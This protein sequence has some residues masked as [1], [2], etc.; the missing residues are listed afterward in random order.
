MGKGRKRENREGA[1]KG[2]LRRWQDVAQQWMA[3]LA[4]GFAEGNKNREDPGLEEQRAPLGAATVGAGHITEG[5]SSLPSEP[6]RFYS[7]Q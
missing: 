4:P 5:N 3:C 7:S 2:Y 6:G 1:D